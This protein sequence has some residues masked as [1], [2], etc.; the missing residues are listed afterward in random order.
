MSIKNC[1]E[2]FIALKSAERKNEINMD[3]EILNTR[4]GFFDL[5]DLVSF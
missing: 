1:N 4:A 2:F 3:S 5:L